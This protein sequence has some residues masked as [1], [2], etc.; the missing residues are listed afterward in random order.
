MMTHPNAATQTTPGVTPTDVP[1]NPVRTVTYYFDTGRWP[2]P[3][4]TERGVKIPY[5]VA[6]N[7]AIQNRVRGWPQRIVGRT[8]FSVRVPAGTAVSLYL[9]T[10]SLEGNRRHPVYAVTPNANDV[11]VTITERRG[12]FNTQATVT[13]DR[14]EIDPQTQRLTDY[15]SAPL[16]GNIW[17]IISK[18]YSETD[19]DALLP[20]NCDAGVREGIFSAYR[21]LAQPTLTVACTEPANHQITVTFADADNARANVSNF[22]NLRDG[23]PRIHPV[24]LFALIDAARVARIRNMNITS[25]WRPLLG[26]IAH[27]AG[28]G[29]DVNIIGDDD[30]QIRLNRGELVGAGQDLPWVTPRERQLFDGRTASPQAREAWIAEMEANKPALFEEFRSALQNS[31]HIQQLLDPWYLD[32]NTR[33]N[34]EPKPNDMAQGNP[35]THKDHLHITVNAPGVL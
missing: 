35:R 30:E 8:R 33:D 14:T 5:Q 21:V 6:F 7:G 2:N 31:A 1:V 28:I 22:D 9:N 34:V 19:A 3:S 15:F 29:L 26:S 27:R 13:F 32:S 24:G 16:H 18:I 20:A 10:D 4:S 17:A 23:I 12:L 11:Y 25:C